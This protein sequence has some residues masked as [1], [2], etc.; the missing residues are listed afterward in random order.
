MISTTSTEHAANLIIQILIV[1]DRITRWKLLSWAGRY[2]LNSKR[3]HK[4][5][6]WRDK[7]A[8]NKATSMNYFQSQMELSLLESN[9]F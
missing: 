9:Y 5:S 8:H 3:Y 7:H 6:H 4:M 2:I 1:F